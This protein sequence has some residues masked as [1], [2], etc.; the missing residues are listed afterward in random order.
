MTVERIEAPYEADERTML[1]SFLDYHRAT[2][3]MKCDGLTHA[4][5]RERS[6]PPSSLSLLGLVRHMAEVERSWFRRA[7]NG[8]DVPTIYY[9]E[10]D[11]DGDFDNIDDADV[12][13]AFATWRAECERARE[14][15]AAAPSLDVAGFRR[16]GDRVTLRWVLVHMIE[17][18][19]RHNGHADLL[20]ERID[21]ATGE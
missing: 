2:L 16:S 21:G 13:D 6:V 4:Q 14:I 7:I 12:D 17:E 15:V 8:E 18:Y 20:R 3:A 9:S 19:A 10:T 11:P 5:L 1:V